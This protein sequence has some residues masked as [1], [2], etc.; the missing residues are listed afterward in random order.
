MERSRKEQGEG[1]HVEQN[2][3]EALATDTAALTEDEVARV[4]EDASGGIVQG[5]ELEA[6]SARDAAI[7]ATSDLEGAASPDKDDSLDGIDP[8]DV[9]GRSELE[10]M[11]VLVIWTWVESGFR[12][13]MAMT[14]A[15]SAGG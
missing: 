5:E 12:G 1:I 14:G 6:G 11:K 8:A 2:D 10:A 13:K 7:R 15:V 3:E 9:P 4:A